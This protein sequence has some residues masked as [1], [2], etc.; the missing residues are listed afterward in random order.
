MSLFNSSNNSLKSTNSKIN[1]LINCSEIAI[2][3]GDNQFK[4]K[5]DYL[6]DVWKKNAKKDYETYKNMTQ[7]VKIS[8]E[9]K[10]RTISDKNNINIE[11]EM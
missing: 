7:F 6:I 1:L 9:D 5:R 3:T 4:S 11:E 2:I 8:D 10:I